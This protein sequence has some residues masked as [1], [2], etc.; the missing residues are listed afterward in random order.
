MLRLFFTEQINRFSIHQAMDRYTMSRLGLVGIWTDMPITQSL[1]N[2]TLTLIRPHTSIHSYN[3]YVLT[4]KLLHCS[5]FAVTAGLLRLLLLCASGSCNLFLA[6]HPLD[7][8]V[9]EDACQGDT[10]SYKTAT[11]VNDND[12]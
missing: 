3:C 2:T 11:L 12:H 10:S 5:L 1:L 9:N 4:Q 6:R 7:L 8:A